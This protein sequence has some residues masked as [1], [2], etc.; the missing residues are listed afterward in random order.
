ME[1]KKSKESFYIRIDKG[2]EVLNI[3][4]D[5]CKK[6]NILSGHFQGIGGCDNITVA[7]LNADTMVFTDHNIKD[8]VIEMVSLLGN[9]SCG[10]GNAIHLHAHA[11][12][13]FINDDNKPDMIAGHLKEA[14]I[15]F[16][17]EIIF[18][19]CDFVIGRQFDPNAGIDVWKLN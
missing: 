18:T 9:V 8:R 6:E 11:S 4:K 19:P 3:I 15:A 12:F 13:S 1:Y 17:G 16:T 5:F 2:E 7:T 10:S 14:Y